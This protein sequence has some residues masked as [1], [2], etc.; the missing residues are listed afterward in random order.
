M[1]QAAI[2]DAITAKLAALAS[3]KVAYGDG[4]VDPTVKPWPQQITDM[5]AVL[6]KPGSDERTL[7]LSRELFVTEWIAEFYLP[8]AADPGLAIQRVNQLR[9]QC[10]VAFRTGLSL[11]GLV[12]VIR[13]VRS[14]APRYVEEGEDDAA[15]AYLI[16]TAVFVTEERTPTQPTV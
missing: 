6:V 14:E 10:R 8:V 12:S 16:W 15:T 3:V 9:D 4:S 1:S 7:G 11:A 5:P 13:Y 2:H